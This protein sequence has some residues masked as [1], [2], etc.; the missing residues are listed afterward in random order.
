MGGP[1]YYLFALEK[2][3]HSPHYE[4]HK[5]D[6]NDAKSHRRSIYRFIVRSQ[7]DPFMTT[8]DCADSSQ[9]TPLRSE[10]LTSLQALS[11]LNNRFNLAMAEHF[12]KRLQAEETETADQVKR[13]VQLTLG[14][15]PTGDEQDQ[16]EAY[17]DKHGLANLCRV[18]FNLSEFVYLD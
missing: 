16:F 14:R 5:F 13:A 15:D 17:A 11:M 18:M 10:T 1:G 7:P 6:A 4:Y 12:A 2:T 3:A 8:L 9:S